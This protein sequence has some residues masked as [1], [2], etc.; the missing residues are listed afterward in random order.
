MTF[1]NRDAKRQALWEEAII[2]ANFD[3][4]VALDRH[5]LDY[6]IGG[7]DNVKNSWEW[8]NR[9]DGLVARIICYV[10]DNLRPSK[11]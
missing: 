8:K 7:I 5:S 3:S 1:V 10:R 6:L 2:A 11:P 9:T 4:R